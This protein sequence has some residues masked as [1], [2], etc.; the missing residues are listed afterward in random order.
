MYHIISNK[1][2]GKSNCFRIG[3]ILTVFLAIL[4][5]QPLL[6]KLFADNL[7]DS[8]H[9]SIGKKYVVIP[10][11]KRNLKNIVLS[12]NA[13]SS[14][15][16]LHHS[17]LMNLPSYTNISLLVSDDVYESVRGS[18][19]DMPFGK[20][21]SVIK[22]ITETKSD[23]TLFILDN[24][25]DFAVKN[26]QK[27]VPIQIGTFWM[28]DIFI[29]VISPGRSKILV[30]P[31]FHMCLWSKDTYS[32]DNPI[33]DNDFIDGLK[34]DGLQQYEIPV[35]FN[36]GNIR[37]GE[38]SGKR[39]AFCG[40]DILL[41]TSIYFK[42]FQNKATNDSTVTNIISETF[43]IDEVVIIDKGTKQPYY[44]FHLD[45]AFVLVADSI[46]CVTR[47][48]ENTQEYEKYKNG[49]DSVE[50]YLEKV[51]DSLTA[52]GLEIVDIDTPVH[53][54]LRQEYYVNAVPFID[55][56]TGEKKILLPVYKTKS[57]SDTETL[58]KNVKKFTSL[59]YQVIPVT[60]K[61]NKLRGGL[62]CMINVIE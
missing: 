33:H 6:I 49:I 62:H 17:L 29:P 54:I 52:S 43:G 8:D 41:N 16:E 11:Y 26:L 9:Q 40:S 56:E 5:L 4:L 38:I 27:P 44:M 45:Q 18:V 15:L 14:S 24:A 23:G 30:T 32:R 53:N 46:A 31:P 7:S 34:G 51:R 1:T 37:F 48:T 10:E 60:M 35:V 22:Y 42:T 57:N 2:S 39:V 13:G 25:K 21:I 28:Q 3:I 36:G 12:L 20:R 47:L 61:E 58:E 50:R 55:A 19:A 59:G